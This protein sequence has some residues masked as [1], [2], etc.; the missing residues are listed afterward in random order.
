MHRSSP[1]IASLAAALA[2]AQA[3]LVNPEKSLTATIRSDG[4]G[5]A[6]QTFRY[7][8]LSSGLDIVR[9]TLGQHEIATVQTTAIDQAAG[10]VNLTTVLAH[11]SGEW[12]ASDWPVCAI[13]DTAT[14]HRM[15]AALTYARR[16]ALFTLVG[17]AGEYDIDAP[18]LTSPGQQPSEPERPKQNRLNGDRRPNGG[19]QL[20]PQRRDVGRPGNAHSSSTQAMLGSEASAEL[21]DRLLGELNDFASSDDAAIWAH[22]CLVE[23]I[24]LTAADAQC[25]EEAFQARLATFV[26]GAG[27]ES[28]T[29]GNAEQLS[30][31]HSPHPKKSKKRSR[32]TVINKSVLALPEP[33]RVRDR[34]HVRYVARQPCLVCDRRPS[35]AHHLRFAQS[36]ALG[37]KVSDEFTVPLCR[38]HHREVHRSD[39]EAAWW[40]S[41]GIDPML[42]ARALWLKTHPLPT[43]GKTDINGA[44]SSATIGSDQRIAK[45]DWPVR[46]RG[47]NYKT[48]PSVAAVGPQ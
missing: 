47:S 26:T 5:G 15:G 4:P 41:A 3:E 1:S 40:T 20:A 36:R 24:R 12:I 11:A 38:G 29:P 32:P 39:D 8:S 9:K 18:D 33:R 13:A 10:I 34:D 28:Q 23:K 45:P 25:V 37:C 19:H 48:K 42:R 21:R 35:D 16:Y 31:P 2:K 14:P 6:D 7:A 44:T 17:I 46:R 27:D 43:T 22:R 30:T